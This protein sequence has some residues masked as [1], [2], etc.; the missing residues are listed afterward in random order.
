MK[1]ENIF[2]TLLIL[3]KKRYAGLA[4][5][6]TNGGSK[7]KIVMKGI[8]TVRRDW[9]DLTSETLYSVLDILLKEGSPK[10]AVKYIKDI[11]NA[12]DKNQVPID[13]LV[14][15]KSISKP[16]KDYKGVQPHVELSK[17]I[18]KRSPAEA[19]GIGDRIG[20]VIVH[21]SQLMSE[22]AEDPSFVVENKLRIDSKYYL[23][24]QLLPPLERVFEAI[25]ISRSDIVNAGKQMML[26]EALRNN[27]VKQTFK[28]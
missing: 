13:K 1:I 14:I 3:S 19:P 10:K 27:G 23:E 7:E 8:E 24:S 20:F 4:V 15:T 26:T 22:R 28:G 16:L 12:L 6:K 25:G 18:R 11:I 5:E 2:K 9:C 17:K 21:G